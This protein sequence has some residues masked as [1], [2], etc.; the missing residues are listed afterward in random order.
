VR[1]ESRRRVR[2]AAL[3][4]AVALA[5]WGAAAG[6]TGQVGARAGGVALPTVGAGARTGPG[7]KR[8]A[9]KQP[10]SLLLAADGTGC[11]VSPDRFRDT[12][13]GDMVNCPDWRAD[14]TDR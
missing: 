3:A 11:D 7:V 9:A 10:P 1:G 5:W 14:P 2:V 6:C 13:V 8:V 12:A 4:A